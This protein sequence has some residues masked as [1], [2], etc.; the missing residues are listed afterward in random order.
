MS[1]RTI[2]SIR[3][4]QSTKNSRHRIRVMSRTHLKSCNHVVR[5]WLD[6]LESAPFDDALPAQMIHEFIQS[7]PIS[8]ELTPCVGTGIRVKMLMI[9]Q[10]SNDWLNVR[11]VPTHADIVMSFKVYSSGDIGI[12]DISFLLCNI[13]R[14]FL[15]DDEPQFQICALS[16]NVGGDY[17]VGFAAFAG[18]SA[19]WIER[20]ET[21]PTFDI[22]PDLTET[23]VTTWP[24]CRDDLSA[25]KVVN[26][27]LKESRMKKSHESTGNQSIKEYLVIEN[28]VKGRR[29]LKKRRLDSVRHIPITPQPHVA[30]KGSAQS[31]WFPFCYESSNTVVLNELLV[32]DND[33]TYGPGAGS[34][35]LERYERATLLGLE[36]PEHAPPLPRKR[37]NV[38]SWVPQTAPVDQQASR[39]IDRQKKV[40]GKQQC[41]RSK[42]LM[43]Q[44]DRQRNNCNAG[45]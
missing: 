17:S 21:T 7:L 26:L 8:P 31:F 20:A 33:A 13:Y 16:F 1:S 40:L 25:A 14:S 36:P 5:R 37:E 4:L 19:K 10:T 35:R 22:V 28:K 24:L 9:F 34:T 2:L 30:Q 42:R 45:E 32:F 18:V 41:R 23:F 11:G 39:I 12:Y 29:R 44:V 15:T 3:P 6:R 27:T 38:T 43:E